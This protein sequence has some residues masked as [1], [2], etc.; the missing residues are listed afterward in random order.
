MQRSTAVVP[1]SPPKLPANRPALDPAAHGRQVTLDH[2]A[3]EVSN[4]QSRKRVLST[5]TTLTII[6][7]PGLFYMTFGV[8]GVTIPA[9]L[10]TGAA[11]SFYAQLVDF[12]SQQINREVV[13]GS[14]LV[15][16]LALWAHHTFADHSP[17]YHDCSPPAPAPVPEARPVPFD[18]IYGGARPAYEAEANEALRAKPAA[19]G[20]MFRD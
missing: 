18:A 5:F 12:F 16:W 19:F 1:A 17:Q 6:V 10:V 15:L 20:P 2:L 7:C 4:R 8:D 9:A 3:R 14:I 13:T 11:G